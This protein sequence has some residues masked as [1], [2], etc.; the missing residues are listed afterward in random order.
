MA[1]ST[2]ARRVPHGRAQRR[3]P[4]MYEME[5]PRLAPSPWSADCSATAGSAAATG[6]KIPP[7]VPVAQPSSVPWVAPGADPSSVVR[8]F[9]CHPRTQHKAFP[10][11]LQ[12]SFVIHRTSAVYPPC[13]TG[14]HHSVHRFIHSLGVAARMAGLAV[15]D[16]LAAC[17][18]APGQRKRMP[19]RVRLPA[20]PAAAVPAMADSP[21]TGRSRAGRPRAPTGWSA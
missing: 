7:S 1:G 8:D 12:D 18:E 4:S 10:R 14:F 6:V 17:R 11:Q 13:I 2:A 3:G 20:V 19:T 21:A 5:G 9:Y 16:G 15:P